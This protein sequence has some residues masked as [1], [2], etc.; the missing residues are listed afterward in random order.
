[1]RTPLLD[2]MA[3]RLREQVELIAMKGDLDAFIAE[4]DALTTTNC[5]WRQYKIGQLTKDYAKYLRRIKEVP[6]EQN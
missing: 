2:N 1:M 3:D 6:H 5:G 4:C